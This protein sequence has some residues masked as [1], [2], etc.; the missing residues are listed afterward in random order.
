MNR[1]KY[2]FA[3][4]KRKA[5]NGERKSASKREQNQAR[6]NYAERE[7]IQDDKSASTNASS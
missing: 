1:K 7:Q 6:L 4:R 2:K 3:T 5:R